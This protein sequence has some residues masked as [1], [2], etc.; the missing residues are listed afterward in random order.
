MRSL[1]NELNNGLLFNT[2]GEQRFIEEL[3]YNNIICNEAI[4][5]VKDENTSSVSVVVRNNDIENPSI[6]K[7]TSKTCGTKLAIKDITPSQIKGWSIVNMT[8]SPKYDIVFGYAGTPKTGEEISGDNYSLLRLGDNKFM[9][10]VCDGM[11][12]GEKAN[13]TSE[14]AISL[15]ENFYKAGFDNDIILSSVNKLL[16]L[17]NEE[18]FTALDICVI[19][20]NNSFADFIKLGATFGFVKHANY[21]DIVESSS[22]PIG[23]LDEMKP[24]ITKT[25]LQHQDMFVLC[26][27]GITDAFKN[28]DTLQVFINNASTLHPQNLADLIIEKA[29]EL[30]NGVAGDDMTVLVGRVYTKV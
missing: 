12:S 3:M 5:Y 9:M 27:D 10:A 11:G 17:N 26:S 25:V 2:T 4:I 20:L 21:T 23:I 28:G 8:T 30:S 14:L 15:V 7:I 18:T 6:T 24:S 16:S 13:K 1:G 22:L 19:D 29:M